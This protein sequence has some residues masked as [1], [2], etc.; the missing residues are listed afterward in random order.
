MNTVIGQPP[1]PV[2]ACTALVE[3][4]ASIEKGQLLDLSEADSHFCSS[5]GATCG[6][7]NQ[8]ACLD[9]IQQR[10]VV[11]I[12]LDEGDAGRQGVAAVAG[13]IGGVAPLPG[14]LQAQR[15]LTSVLELVDGRADV[16]DR[17]LEL[18]HRR[19]DIGGRH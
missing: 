10:G 1:R 17:Q 2:I 16:T 5:H 7:W 14:R 11:H 6:G 9:Q 3:S 19:L 8:S 4:M 13:K 15:R 18:L 12:A